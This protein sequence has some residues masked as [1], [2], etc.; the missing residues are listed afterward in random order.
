MKN[1]LLE[2]V[3]KLTESGTSPGREVLA[4]FVS[5]FTIV[6]IAVVNGLILSEGGIP[7]EGAILATV[8]LSAVSC[9]LVGFWSN[10]PI[11]LVPGMGLNAFFSYTMVHSMGLSWQS[12]LGVVF[13]SG[14]IFT[15]LSFSRFSILLSESIPDSLKEAITVGL[16]LFLILLGLEKGGIVVK[17]E[18][19]I[20]ALGDF[21][22]PQ[23]IASILTVLVAFILF[24]RNV[25]GNFLITI[26]A[27]CGIAYGLGTLDLSQLSF[28]QSDFKAYG[29][30][31]GAFSFEQAAGVP[32]WTAVFSLTMVLV[33]ENIGLVHGHVNSIKKPELY[34]KAFQSTGL[35]VLLSG[36]F[37]SSPT[38]ASVETAAGVASGGRTGLTAIT[39]GVLFAASIFFIPL[40]KIIPDSAIA[41]ILIIIGILMLQN[42]KNLE[43]KDFSEAIPAFLTI[44]LIPF[45]YSIAD[46]MA[47]GFIVYPLLKITLGKGKDVSIIM[48][49]IAGLFLA[50]FFVNIMG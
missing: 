17:G 32:F 3:F 29:E 12:A 16:G 20:L 9:I 4:G 31:F 36:I 34:Q 6:Y 30:V 22:Q 24:I 25:R 18:A 8:L 26:I 48:Y 19:T 47:I 41:P 46:G 35:S 44:T 28:Q 7:M 23:V 11:I 42:I 33:F 39:T 1:S 49:I 2:R 13:V 21:S 14:L 5:Y 38:V 50:N 10:V 43:L 45:T 40:I 27:G 37:G 15:F